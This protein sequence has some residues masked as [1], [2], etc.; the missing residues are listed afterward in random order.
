MKKLGVLLGILLVLLPCHVMADTTL[1][2]DI[3]AATIRVEGEVTGVQYDGYSVYCNHEGYALVSVF[4]ATE[5]GSLTIQ[6][7]VSGVEVVTAVDSEANDTE[8]TWEEF[9]DI[10]GEFPPAPPD[11]SSC[12]VWTD[13]FN[14]G[15]SVM[16]DYSDGGQS[17][18]SMND[19]AFLASVAIGPD[20]PWYWT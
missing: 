2:G 20:S 7:N 3:G 16:G 11:A 8:L 13:P 12:D 5:H 18:A 9:C 19:A 10:Y 4:D 14:E 6:G 15:P 1:T 17:V